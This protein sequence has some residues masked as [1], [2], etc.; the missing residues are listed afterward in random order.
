MDAV[1][2]LAQAGHINIVLKE[3]CTYTLKQI[4][5]HEEFILIYSR[6]ILLGCSER[7]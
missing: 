6:N 3:R 4:S 5:G 1:N 2:P 7:D